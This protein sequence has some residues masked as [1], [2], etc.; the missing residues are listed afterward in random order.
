MKNKYEN[1]L[2]KDEDNIKEEYKNIKNVYFYLSN[3]ISKDALD[4]IIL[5]L[6]LENE[7]YNNYFDL[8]KYLFNNTE[9]TGIEYKIK[10][11]F[12]NKIYNYNDKKFLVI[13]NKNNIIIYLFDNYNFTLAEHE[14]IK[15]FNIFLENLKKSYE[16]N[17]IIGFLDYYNNQYIFKTINI[18]NMRSSGGRCNVITKTLVESQINEIIKDD[19][20]FNEINNSLNK[21]HRDS[22]C[23]I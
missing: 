14:D 22:L 4:T 10:E 8:L 3:Y 12:S 6:L 9:L 13:P 5:H 23:L 21:F 20:Y 19:K 11:Y 17:K 18:Y 2:N 7:Y 15:E 16:F 1:I